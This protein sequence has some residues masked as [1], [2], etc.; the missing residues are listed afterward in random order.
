[1]PETLAGAER[2]FS[3]EAEPRDV[4]DPWNKPLKQYSFGR[5]DILTR[6]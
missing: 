2:V 3:G 1:M 4:I 6:Q 5:F